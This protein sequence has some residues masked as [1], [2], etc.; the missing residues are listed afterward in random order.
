MLTRSFAYYKGIQNDSRNNADGPR[1]VPI[2]ADEAAVPLISPV[3]LALEF[4][5]V[6]PHVPTANCAC[7]TCIMHIN[8]S[9]VSRYIRPHSHE[10]MSSAWQTYQGL[11][12]A[13]RGHAKA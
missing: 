9:H 12:V 5:K 8:T 10:L 4:S 7:K 1:E 6:T 2:D 3:A 13:T 11:R